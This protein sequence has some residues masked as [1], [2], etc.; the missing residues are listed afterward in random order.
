MAPKAPPLPRPT[1][2][3]P[4]AR[5]AHTKVSLE[6]CMHMLEADF[7]RNQVNRLIFQDYYTGS[8]FDVE[9]R[10]SVGRLLNFAKAARLNESR[11]LFMLDGATYNVPLS[12]KSD[13]EER[14]TPPSA[15]VVEGRKAENLEWDRLVKRIREAM[16]KSSKDRTSTLNV[17]MQGFANFM[18]EDSPRSW[19]A[20]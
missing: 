3:T 4:K 18:G 8:V 1:R 7:V 10:K 15:H 5:L 14:W 6:N 2:M 12:V 19:Q 16:K 20:K 9:G 13:K 17:G 11:L